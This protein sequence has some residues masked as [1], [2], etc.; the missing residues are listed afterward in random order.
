[1][2]GIFEA[3]KFIERIDYQNNY[4]IRPF[5]WLFHYKKFIS[6]IPIHTGLCA[7]CGKLKVEHQ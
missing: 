3:H 4:E 6:R 5:L 2:N 1:M 7:V